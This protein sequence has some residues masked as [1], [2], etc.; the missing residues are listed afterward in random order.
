MN[1]SCIRS[2]YIDVYCILYI[3][4]RL[5]S[6]PSFNINNI[7]IHLGYP[8]CLHFVTCIILLWIQTFH[9]LSRKISVPI[10]HFHISKSLSILSPRCVF[11]FKLQ[12]QTVKVDCS[13]SSKGSPNIYLLICGVPRSSYDYKRI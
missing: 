2:G 7:F 9:H 3:L 13:S 11:S 8:I 1:L 6:S 5:V 12:K 10:F 4:K